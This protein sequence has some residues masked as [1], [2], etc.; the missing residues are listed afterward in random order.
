MLVLIS[1]VKTKERKTVMKKLKYLLVLS[2]LIYMSY[3]FYGCSAVQFGGDILRSGQKELNAAIVPGITSLDIVN[4]S[5]PVL[6]VNGIAPNGQIIIDYTPGVTNSNIYTDMFMMELM[7]KGILVTTLTESTADVIKNH[8]F[9]KLDAEGN[10]LAIIINTN[11][12]SSSSITELTTGGEYQKIGVTAFTIKGI[13]TSDGKVIFMGSGSYG[14]AK[15]AGEVS[16]D[17]GFIIDN[18]YKGTIEKIKNPD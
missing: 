7:N 9:S 1:K 6:A 8:N 15:D 14:K 3:F 10:M 12:A 5:N 11:L 16:K 4:L 13:R 18:I 2:L 17:V